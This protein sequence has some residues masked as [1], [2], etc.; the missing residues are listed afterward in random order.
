MS[1]EAWGVIGVLVFSA[2]VGTIWS[3]RKYDSMAASYRKQSEVTN[4]L[5]ARSLAL[6][7]RHEQLLRRAESLLD[8]LERKETPPASS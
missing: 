4:E 7:E 2:V 5:Q 1:I 8:R 3:A 6:L